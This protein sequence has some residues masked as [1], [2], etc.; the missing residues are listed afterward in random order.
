M[1]LNAVIHAV[2]EK[3]ARDGYEKRT[4]YEKIVVDIADLEDD[5]NND[6]FDGYFFNLR[7]DH[8]AEAIVALKTIGAQRM[9]AIVE[10][11][12][13]LFPN[14][15]PAGHWRIRQQQFDQMPDGV[16]NSFD[17]EFFKY[18]DPV[19]ELLSEYLLNADK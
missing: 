3:Q 15:W 17:R 2:R 9:A 19:A 11:A 6:G 5:V 8:F 18:P 10:A 7:G 14:G 1:D 13:Q 12:C 4:A 16:F